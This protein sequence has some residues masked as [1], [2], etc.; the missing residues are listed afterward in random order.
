MEGGGPRAQIKPSVTPSAGNVRKPVLLNKL[1]GSPDE[2]HM[3]V[4]IPREDGV[5]SVCDDRTVRVW[6]KR[7]TG[8]FWPSICHCMPVAPTSLHYTPETRRLFIGLDNGTIQE[9]SLADDF[10]RM[11][12]SRTYLAHQ[13]RVTGIIYALTC[14]WLL[15]T[16]RDKYFQWH[17]SETGRRLGGFQTSAWC[18]C[19]QFD[20]Q[21]R[22]AFV[23]DYSGQVTVI[24]LLE[25]RL[26]VITTL[27][28]HSGS[29]RCLSWDVE[30]SLL[31]SGSFDQTII[32]WDIGGQQGTAFEL[33]GHHDKVQSVI[34]AA[35]TK[36]LLSAGDDNALVIWTM[37]IKRQETPEWA[38]GDHCQKCGTPFFWNLKKMW[39]EKTIGTRQHHCRKCGKAVCDKCSGNRTSIPIMGYEFD[40]RVCAECSQTVTDEDRVPMATFHDSRH[41]I[42]HMD[43]DEIRK[44]L[45]TVGKDK[46]IKLW[47]V[48]SVLH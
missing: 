48:S 11:T 39:E 3:A 41:S 19:L 42:V 40:V 31:F 36:Q 33:Q 44:I 7:D 30:R 15:S 38:E 8:Q 28:G 47:D 26:E 27:K 24:K 1:E 2:I 10:N 32:V 20:S 25:N 45:L 22:Y 35:S 6:L 23:G 13:S 16:G 5:I 34:Y 9:F 37:D 21:S 14:E 29:I 12:H 46:V 17:C 18:T 43:L 4:L